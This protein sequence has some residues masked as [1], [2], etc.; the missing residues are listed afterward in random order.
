MREDRRMK[1]IARRINR[2]WLFRVTLLLIAVNL[3]VAGLTV[4]G[5]C[6]LAEET[7]GGWRQDRPARNL[8][9]DAAVST[10]DR[11]LTITYTFADE[12]GNTCVASGYGFFQFV[13]ALF[14]VLLLAEALLLALHG[15]GGRRRA[16]RLLLPLEKMAATTQELSRASLDPEKL[17]DLEDAIATVSPLAPNAKLTTGDRELQGLETAVNDLLRRMRESYR[18]QSRFVS[19]ASHELRTPI[20]VIQGYADMLSRWGKGDEKVLE[21]GISAIQS[22]SAHMKT[23]IEQLLFLARGDSGRNQLVLE[24]VDLA[25][26]MQEVMDE[27]QMI[28]PNRRWKLRLGQEMLLVRGDAAMLK[29]TARILVDNAVRYTS[30]DDSIALIAQMQDGIPCFAVQDN[31]MGIKAEDLNHIFDR[32]YRSDPARARATGGTGLGLS[33]AQWIVERH[34]GYFE[35]FS[36]EEVGTRMS[37]LLPRMP[38]E[39]DA[40]E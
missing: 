39:K 19:D 12:S 11:P 1:S 36:R 25:Q 3:V 7:Q 13:R 10:W 2:S 16:R 35:V 40:K 8:T 37:V 6:Y 33:I 32:F 38:E 4:F 9:W 5:F 15:L 26:M 27:S 29:Q 24:E 28:H 31:G 22:E 30:E 21:E 20:A 34:G 23:L 18:E 14:G 17:H